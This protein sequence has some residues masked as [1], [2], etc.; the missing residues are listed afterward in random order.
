MG[1]KG[2]KIIQARFRDAYLNVDL[3]FN[4]D[5]VI[6]EQAYRLGNGNNPRPIIAKFLNFKDKQKIQNRI[7]EKLNDD[8][9]EWENPHRV[10]ED[11][12]QGVRDQRKALCLTWKTP[13]RQKNNKKTTN[14]QKTTTTKKNNNKKQQQKNNNKKQED[15]DGPISLTWANRFAYLLLKFQPSSQDFCINFIAPTPPPTLP[16]TTTPP[17]MIF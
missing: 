14:K 1:F 11:F 6:I 15:H 10:R 12:T 17:S 8:E 2:V 3:D 9:L 5:N 13:G 7:K 16:R 4:P